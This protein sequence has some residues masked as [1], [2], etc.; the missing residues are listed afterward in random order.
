M[1]LSHDTHTKNLD[2][3]RLQDLVRCPAGTGWSRQSD[4]MRASQRVHHG[5]G[6]APGQ[7]EVAMAVET[8][9]HQHGAPWGGGGEE[10][11]GG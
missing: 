10:G 3:E 2:L 8:E 5:E 4:V 9:A 6:G 7:Q 11:G 1:R